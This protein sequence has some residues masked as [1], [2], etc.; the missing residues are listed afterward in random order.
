MLGRWRLSQLGDFD[1]PP[2]R[3]AN[4]LSGAGGLNRIFSTKAASETAA[5]T[6]ENA[7]L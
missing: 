5:S 1:P 4:D 6:A 2:S 7:T 3:R